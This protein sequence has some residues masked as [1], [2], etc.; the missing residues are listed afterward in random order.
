MSTADDPFFAAIL[1]DLSHA[2]AALLDPGV[3]PRAQATRGTELPGT[4][5]GLL[6]DIEALTGLVPRLTSELEEGANH[7]ETVLEHVPIPRRATPSRS[8][9]DYVQSGHRLVPRTWTTAVPVL[10]PDPRPL[11]WVLWLL[12]QLDVQLDVHRRRLSTVF[13]EALRDRDVASRFAAAEAEELRR[14]EARLRAAAVALRRSRL[15]VLR[16]ASWRLAPSPNRPSPFPRGTAWSS[17]RAVAD[18]VVHPGLALTRTLQSALR[19]PVHIADR[20]YLYQRWVGLKV[21]DL[22]VAG[23]WTVR[24]DVVRALFLGGELG[25]DRGGTTITLWLEPRLLA[26]SDHPSGLRATALETSPDL[27]FMTPGP[28]GRDAFVLDPTLSGSAE[29]LHGKAKYLHGIE[30]VAPAVVAG[31]PVR[32][33]PTRSWG[34]APLRRATCD[35]TSPSGAT[36]TVPAWPVEFDGTA[37]RAWLGD[38]ERHA[39]AWTPVSAR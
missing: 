16:R 11:S 21:I 6:H 5:T 22:L 23:G 13:E 38:V 4:L 34:V 31:V 14:T 17:L 20:G 3:A 2:A 35:L 26:D 29:V 30:F 28:H 15:S 10:E 33:T 18:L 27:I 19:P 1:R 39:A 12:D 25:F 8:A 7:T 9:R 32:R 37:L 36:G 24:G